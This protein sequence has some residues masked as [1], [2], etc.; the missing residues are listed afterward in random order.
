MQVVLMDFLIVSKAH[1][2]IDGFKL[3]KTTSSFFC[4]ELFMKNKLLLLTFN[5][6]TMVIY[7]LSYYENHHPRIR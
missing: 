6:R 3:F 7:T 4:L 1:D 5:T 2:E